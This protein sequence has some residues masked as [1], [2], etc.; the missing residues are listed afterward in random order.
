MHKTAFNTYQSNLPTWSSNTAPANHNKQNDTVKLANDQAIAA[1][2][3]LPQSSQDPITDDS[4]NRVPICN[5]F[6]IP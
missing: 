2:A 4:E 1:E 6:P 3:Q 5:V